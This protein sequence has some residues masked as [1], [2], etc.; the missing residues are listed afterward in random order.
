MQMW[1]SNTA[2]AAMMLPIMD[3]VL[4]E[5]FKQK[6]LL[7]KGKYLLVIHDLD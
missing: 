7:A 1:I 4:E 3:S 6:P 5:M 2:A